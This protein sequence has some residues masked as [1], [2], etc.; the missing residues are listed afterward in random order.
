LGGKD[1]DKD[2]DKDKVVI[3]T[4][5]PLTSG[6][7]GVAYNCTFEAV[8]G[9]EPYSWRVDDTSDLPGGLTLSGAGVLSGT[10]SENGDFIFGVGVIDNLGKKANKQFSITIAPKDKPPLEL[11]ITSIGITGNSDDNF[12]TISSVDVD[13]AGVAVT[14]GEFETTVDISTDEADITI[15]SS[16]AVPNKARAIIRIR[17]EE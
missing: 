6:M 10:P 17:N 11:Q 4:D 3:I 7:V 12:A 9:T 1:K 8:N 16:D 2:K 5:S 15:E 13:G 14:E